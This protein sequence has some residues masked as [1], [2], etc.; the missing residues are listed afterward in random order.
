[1]GK[2][3]GSEQRGERERGEER[4]RISNKETSAKKNSLRNTTAAVSQFD[5]DTHSFKERF[6][7]SVVSLASFK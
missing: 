1:M 5:K 2:I 6:L 4:E 7:F 3:T